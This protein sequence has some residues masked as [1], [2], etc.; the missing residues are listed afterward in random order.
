MKHN[1]KSFLIVIILFICIFFILTRN[2]IINTNKETDQVISGVINSVKINDVIL[3]VEVAMTSEEH[4][5]GLSDRES[6]DADAGLLFF[7]NNSGKYPFWMKDMNFP[8]DIIW[9]DENYTI[10][11]I[12]KNAKPESFPSLLGGKVQSRY[13]LETASGFS[14]KNNI[15]I[16]DTVS[17]FS[18][19]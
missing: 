6:L 13:V 4:A 17:F 8:I 18:S 12:E 9:I 5:K 11:F 7:F 14:Q 16:G 19:K 1:I 15:K 2:N 3:K 10:V